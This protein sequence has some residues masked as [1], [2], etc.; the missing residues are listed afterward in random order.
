MGFAC[1]WGEVRWSVLHYEGVTVR[2]QPARSECG[3]CV[4][5][6]DFPQNFGYLPVSYRC[7]FLGVD[8]CL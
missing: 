1:E 6:D 3:L 4:Y 7:P 8:L 2:A 5:G